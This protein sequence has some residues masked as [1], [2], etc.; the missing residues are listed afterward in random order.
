MTAQ[1]IPFR[2]RKEEPDRSLRAQLLMAQI[3]AQ[4]EDDLYDEPGKPEDGL[5]LVLAVIVDAHYFGPDHA[6]R[7]VERLRAAG[8]TLPLA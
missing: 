7:Y 4:E 3:E 6:R 2:P 1:V 5:D 8:Y